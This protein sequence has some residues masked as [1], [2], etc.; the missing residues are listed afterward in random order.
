METDKEIIKSVKPTKQI[1]GLDE[2]S[3]F[4]GIHPNNP[5]TSFTWLCIPK[6]IL[7]IKILLYIMSHFKVLI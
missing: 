3:V 4:V 7:I 1:L 6:K 2:N 5:F